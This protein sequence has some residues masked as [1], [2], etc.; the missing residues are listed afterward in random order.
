MRRWKNNQAA[1]LGALF[2]NEGDFIKVNFAEGQGR[3]SQTD[4][5]TFRFFGEVPQSVLEEYPIKIFL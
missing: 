4:S 2:N 3:H 1:D 5:D